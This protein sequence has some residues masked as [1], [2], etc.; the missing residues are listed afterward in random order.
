M[1]LPH[2][3]EDHPD[4]P[5]KIPGRH[6]TTS[7]PPSLPPW[8]TLLCHLFPYRCHRSRFVMNVLI[9]GMSAVF[10]PALCHVTLFWLFTTVM[11]TRC[12]YHGT[13]MYTTFLSIVWSLW[14]HVHTSWL[15]CSLWLSCD[16]HVI[17]MW[18]CKQD[19]AIMELECIYITTVTTCTHIMTVM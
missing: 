5:W 1:Q 15:S 12:S 7:F 2:R 6:A 8:V 18:L 16:Y 11:Q 4:W 14:L 3:N 9:L 10:S 13:W 19:V 17:I